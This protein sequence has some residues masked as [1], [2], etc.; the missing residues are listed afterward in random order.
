MTAIST[1][2]LRTFTAVVLLGIVA[3]SFAQGTGVKKRR[4]LPDEFGNVVMNNLSQK[5]DIAPVVFSHWLH[6]SRFTCRLC[7]V[8]IGF[9]MQANG[10]MVREEDNRKGSYCGACHNGKVAFAATTH[11]GGSEVKNCARCHSQGVDVP[12]A[13][14]FTTFVA[15]FP[16]G[17]FGNKVDWEA[18]ELANKIT[19]IDTLP[20]VSVK[21]AALAVP[22]DYAIEAKINGLPQIIFSHKKHAVWNGCELCHPDIFTVKSGGTKYTMQ[23]IF[24]SKYCGL[25]HGSV[26]FPATDCQRCHVQPV[27]AP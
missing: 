1:A 9:A 21:R 3:T 19:L 10:T 27:T 14:N 8:D 26:A 20:E 17:R 18:A 25:C 23:D 2:F 5:N 4:P 12:H 22:K 15:D 6:R 13:T 7:H 24:A 11:S 16:K